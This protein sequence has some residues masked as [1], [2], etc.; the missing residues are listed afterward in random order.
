MTNGILKSIV[1]R[2][3]LLMKHRQLEANSE[4]FETSKRNLK[5]FN[6]ILRKNIREAKTKFYF[7]T[8]EK[9]KFDIKNTW[10]NI[11]GLISKSNRKEIR[12]L[13][14]NGKKVE[15][16]QQIADEFNTFFAN[17]GAKLASTIDTQNKKPYDYYLNKTIS[18]SFQVFEPN[19]AYRNVH[20][21]ICNSA[22]L[23]KLICL[24]LGPFGRF[25]WQ[26]NFNSFSFAVL[27]DISGNVEDK[28]GFGKIYC[29][30]LYNL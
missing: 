1:Y 15:D 21:A 14:I 2:D 12:Q 9:Y 29:L 7:E 19:A 22:S 8:F 20:C 26:Q 16:K 4:I 5:T 28:V 3:K 27:F 6:T 10:K 25:N 24:N 11:N 17:I 13:L 18:T 30:S 23:D